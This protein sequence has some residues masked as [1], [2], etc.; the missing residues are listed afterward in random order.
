MWKDRNKN[1]F[2]AGTQWQRFWYVKCSDFWTMARNPIKLY[3]H[4]KI[5]LTLK[6]AKTFVVRSLEPPGF[7]L[8]LPCMWAVYR[9]AQI[10]TSAHTHTQTH[11]LYALSHTHK[12]TNKGE[13]CCIPVDAGT[14][15]TRP[16]S[17]QEEKEIRGYIEEPVVDSR[18]FPQP[19]FYRVSKMLL[20]TVDQV[21]WS[22]SS[23]PIWRLGCWNEIPTK[24]TNWVFL[25]PGAVHKKKCANF[26][27]KRRIWPGW[28]LAGQ[29][30]FSL[31]PN[32]QTAGGAYRLWSAMLVWSLSGIGSQAKGR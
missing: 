20:H 22:M 6:A 16:P 29:N 21:L 2:P 5:V 25:R 17:W 19:N 8:G 10:Q 23:P 18:F 32:G 4:F 12:G 11:I 30:R 9:Q 3:R 7:K 28:R 26:V 14:V 1:W 31:E 13:P 27:Q 15:Q 24:W